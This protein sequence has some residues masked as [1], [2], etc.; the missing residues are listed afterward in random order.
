M[1]LQAVRSAATS[2]KLYWL[3]VDKENTV[4]IS[5][6]VFIMGIYYKIEGLGA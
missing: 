6:G 3:P 2:S 5:E 1:R 4:F